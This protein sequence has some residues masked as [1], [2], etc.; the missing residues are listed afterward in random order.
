MLARQKVD[1]WSL[2]SPFASWRVQRRCP[3]RVRWS[4][5]LISG[6]SVPACHSAACTDNR[7]GRMGLI[8]ITAGGL[9]PDLLIPITAT[10]PTRPTHPK[11][12]LETVFA[13][14]RH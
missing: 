1:V 10:H 4:H 9:R 6:S 2:P 14:A 11:E 8:L 13:S 5:Q 7:V 12:A 3:C